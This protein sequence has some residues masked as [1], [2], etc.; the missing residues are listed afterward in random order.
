[1]ETE[2]IK[3]TMKTMRIKW[4]RVL[5]LPRARLL[6]AERGAE[7]QTAE[8]AIEGLVCD[9]CAARVQRAL[10]ALPGVEEARVDLESGRAIVRGRGALEAERL[11]EAV[12][13][14]V[15]LWPLRRLLSLLS[16]PRRR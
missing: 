11:R 5:V 15:L 9:L 7:G 14:Q 10:L 4:R 2:A 16:R 8:L 1:M 6:R 12:R 13:L 3:A